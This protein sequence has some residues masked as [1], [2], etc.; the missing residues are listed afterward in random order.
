MVV[1]QVNVC[2]I[3]KSFPYYPEISS[4]CTLHSQVQRVPL[5]HE[6]IFFHSQTNRVI[7][8]DVDLPLSD[9]WMGVEGKWGG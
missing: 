9:E 4:G 1:S 2:F 3:S 5:N 8:N 7:L 6:L